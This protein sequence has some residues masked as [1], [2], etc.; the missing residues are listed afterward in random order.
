LNARETVTSDSRSFY[1]RRGWRWVLLFGFWTLPGLIFASLIHA[2]MLQVGEES[3]FWQWIGSQQSG[4]Y[5][6]ALLTPVI[7]W[8]G[9]RFRLDRAH[10]VRNLAVH[11]MAM[12][13]LGASEIMVQILGSML[14]HGE[15]LTWTSYGL[16]IWRGFI[17]DGPW[18]ILIYW[19]I[20]GISYAFD[21][22][23]SLREK[24]LLATRLEA[25]ISRAKLDAL[26]RQ[27]QP[28]FLFNTLNS[29]SVLV[30]KGANESANRMLG[31]LSELLRYVLSRDNGLQVPLADELEFVRRYSDIERTRFGDRLEV[32]VD[33]AP[34]TLGCQ[35]PGFVLQ[36]LVENA[37]RHG[38]SKQAKNGVVTIS[39]ARRDGRLYLE[40]ADNGPGLGDAQDNG[41]GI[42][43]RN[44]RQRLAH[45]YGPDQALELSNR[46]GGGTVARLEI[47]VISQPV[48]PA[49]HD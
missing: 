23:S 2:R 11:F 47:P 31:D 29:I 5:M 36:S 26:Q 20:L 24:E 32:T 49:A 28:H 14:S 22:R 16:G 27:L 39:A 34:D 9:R 44:T 37:I 38:T 43:I 42:G 12:L 4:W 15:T 46:P 6:W 30:Q 7:W 3:H 13:V 41:D 45:L 1:Q 33:A 10:W 48:S 25:E 8:L 35:V 21:Y 17:W 19:A 40:V 18:S